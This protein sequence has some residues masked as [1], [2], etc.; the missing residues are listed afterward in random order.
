MN[1][2]FYFI[3][4]IIIVYTFWLV[5][6][7][8]L[9]PVKSSVNKRYYL[10]NNIGNP[11][12]AADMLGT[13]HTRMKFLVDNLDE[14]NLYFERLKKRFDD[15]ELM[16]NPIM[17]P[18]KTMTSYSINK[19]EKLVFC[20]RNPDTLEMYNINT[21]M[22]VVLH[23]YSHIACPEIGHT[24]LFIEIFASLLKEAIKY[25]VYSDVNYKIEPV[26]YCGLTISERII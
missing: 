6:I 8:N 7:N 4:L 1:S 2:I 15:V 13:I 20:L 11:Q 5:N 10:V 26:S 14:K 17:K 22:Y 19:G 23:E 9:T 18:K 16:E 25:G 3:L 12:E 24:K 21:I